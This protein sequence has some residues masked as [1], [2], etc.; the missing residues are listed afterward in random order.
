MLDY[1]RQRKQ[2]VPV[3]FVIIA[4]IIFSGMWYFSV[5]TP[6]YAVVIDG[7]QK[8]VV[9]DRSTVDRAL[10]SLSSRQYN[11]LDKQPIELANVVKIKQVMAPRKEILP[12]NKVKSVLCK[13]IQFKT[14]AVAIVV[15]GKT[16]TYVVNKSVANALLGKIKKQYSQVDQGEKLISA[17]IQEKVTL[18]EKEAAVAQVKTEKQAFD[19]ITTGSANP[20]KYEVKEGDS[21]WL[22]ARRNDMYVDDIKKANHL[23]SENLQLGQKLILLKSE[24]YINV[25][26]KVEGQKIEVIP[27][28]TKILTDRS[29]PRSIRIKQQGKTGEKQIAY[30]AT[31]CNGVIS[32]KQVLGEQILKAAI[33]KIIV[34][35]SRV[36]YVASRSNQGSGDLDWPVHGTITQYFGS[37]TG[38]DI[39]A[40]SGTAIRAADGGR[41][42]FAGYDGG[43]GRFIIINHGNGLVTRYAH[44][45]SIEVSEGENVAKGQVIGA[46]GSTGHSTG[47]HLHFEVLAGGAFRNPLSYLR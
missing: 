17:R 16:V 40:R 36:T 39:A 10:K 29:A 32:Q 26:A 37:H 14:K 12:A 18:K 7:K 20:E 45:S 24:P 44:C 11:G 33:D 6:A 42:T 13:D 28:E 4:L 23:Q 41:V 22:I 19:L 1:L 35:G 47:P 34:K 25:I 21:L 2:S 43:Y 27:F 31:K 3:T 9:K 15:N 8:F 38:I 46:V 30:T 5:K